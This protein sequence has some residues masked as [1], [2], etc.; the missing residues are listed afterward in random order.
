[1]SK[2]NK[3]AKVNNNQGGGGS[4]ISAEEWSEWNDYLESVVNEATNDGEDMNQV[5]FISGI[6]DSGT[7]PAQKPYTVYDEA[8]EGSPESHK[9][10]KLLE[11][12]FGCYVE[13]GKFYIPNKPMDSV[14]LL[15]DFPEVMVDYNKHPSVKDGNGEVKP[16]RA[17]LAGERDGVAQ[18]TYLTPR[19]QGY[20]SKSRIAKLSKATGC[21][22][23]NPS[24][25]FD[26][27]ELLGQPFTMDI[28]C[29]RG[30]NENQFLNIKVSNPSSKHKAIPV[31]E[32]NVEPFGI[33]MD[34]G[35]EEKDLIQIA[36]KRAIINRL[37][38][39]EEWENSELKKELEALKEKKA[40][41]K[42]SENPSEKTSTK[43]K[44]KASPKK[45]KPVEEPTEL[46]FDDDIPF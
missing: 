22:K 12:D 30:G 6:I 41:D 36:Y 39:A 7:Q 1:M 20:S 45:E 2:F 9:Q 33:M 11:A 25:D 32:H 27:G 15:V 42:A 14:L 44:A 21:T 13:D 29:S 10:S 40:S 38:M 34:G 23:G 43:S 3:K 17:L 28:E 31:P 37:E 26:I 24:K 35:N 4:N 18:V 19:E 5:C 46:D 16:Y 8:E